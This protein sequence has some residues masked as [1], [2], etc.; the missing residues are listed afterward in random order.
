MY[1]ANLHVIGADGKN[2]RTRGLAQFFD[3]IRVAIEPR[4]ADS[5]GR[6]RARDLRQSR[7]SHRLEPNRTRPVLGLCLNGAKNLRG[8]VDG[9]VVRGNNLRGYSELVRGLLGRP[10]LLDLIIGIVGGE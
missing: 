9:L 2:R 10:R 1:A 4:P 5:R 8:L 7:A 3:V 6:R